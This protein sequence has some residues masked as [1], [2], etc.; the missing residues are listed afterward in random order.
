MQAFEE[1]EAKWAEFC[2]CPNTVAC[3]SGTAALHLAIEALQL[4]PNTPIIVPEFTMIACARAVSLAGM[5]CEFVDCGD[6]LLICPKLARCHLTRYTKA[7]M[8]V[9]IYGRRCDMDGIVS[10]AEEYGLY[11]IEDLAEAHGIKQHPATTASCWSFYKNKIVAG[12]EGGMIAFK[13]PEYATIARQLRSLGFTDDHDFQHRPRGCNYRLANL[14]ARP[15]LDSLA[16]FDENTCDRRQIETWYDARLPLEWKMPA[17]EA[18]W[19]YDLRIPGMTQD[20]QNQVVRLLN[21]Q[22]IAARHAFKP[23]SM[24]SEYARSYCS[25][26]AWKMSKE[27]IYI[28][29]VPGMAESTVEHNIERLKAAV[30]NTHRTSAR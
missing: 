15:I 22:G 20:Q 14:L 13:S 6:D 23:M 30:E 5:Q 17:R 10:F 24:Q 4:R 25:L 29:V 28:P 7:I 21:D 1:L 11:I 2:G 12:E 26:N 8:P 27:V 16:W 9:H 18:V 3:N 19:V